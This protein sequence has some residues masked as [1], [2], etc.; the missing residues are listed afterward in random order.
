MVR[1]RT[2][3]KAPKKGWFR[4]MG[5]G[6]RTLVVVVGV[7]VALALAATAVVGFL[8][9][10]LSSAYDGAETIAVPFPDESVRPQKDDDDGSQTILLIGSDTRGEADEGI[11]IGPQ[12]GRSDTIILAHIPEDQENIVFVS[13]MRDSWVDI[14]GY[15]PNK[16]NAAL[17]YGGV[18]LAVQTLETLF[19]TRIDEVS[20]IDFEGFKGLTDA[21]GGV[22]VNNSRAFTSGDYTFEEGPITLNG[23]EALT[24]VRTRKAFGE[25]DYQRVKNQQLYLKSV[26]GQLL[27]KDTL[28]SPNT[29]IEVVEEVAPFLTVSDGLNTGYFLKMAPGLASIRSQDL[30][31][32]TAPTEGVGVSDDGQS[33]VIL[34]TEGMEKLREAFKND[35]LAEYA[36]DQS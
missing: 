22:T 32:I 18:P 24:F 1:P 25:G 12:D 2:S 5:A 3:R 34:D 10:R 28:S 31:F 23:E 7:V 15:G 6:A 30:L 16:V 35:T 11:L 20:V 13:V 36:R 21:L 9:W 33:I 17:A 27:S 8:A 26:A 4:S 29:V 14:P 19:D